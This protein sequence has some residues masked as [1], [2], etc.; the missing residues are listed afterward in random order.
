MPQCQSKST[1]PPSYYT[2][3]QR[4]LWELSF[5]MEVSAAQYQ[6]NSSD[7]PSWNGWDNSPSFS[8]L[9]TGTW[10]FLGGEFVDMPHGNSKLV[11]P[12][13]WS[14]CATSLVVKNGSP[15]HADTESVWGCS[16]LFHE[17]GAQS[18]KSLFFLVPVYCAEVAS[19]YVTHY[20]TMR[21]NCNGTRVRMEVNQCWSCDKSLF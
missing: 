5:F 9:S 16:K 12:N 15:S 8:G 18:Q 1:C 14:A 6:I 3:L 7:S 11:P 10:S 2:N 21:N 13:D 19:T 4:E 20:I 17:E